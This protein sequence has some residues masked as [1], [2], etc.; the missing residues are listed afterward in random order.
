[1]AAVLVV[2]GCNVFA[3]QAGEAPTRTLTPAPV[4]SVTA[5]TPRESPGP[6]NCVAPP[7]A[8]PVERATP[9]PP[10]TAR[11]LPRTNTTGPVS[12][13]G[14][15]ALHDA[16]LRNYSYRLRAGEQLAVNATAGGRA[17]TFS[18]IVGG[19]YFTDAYAVGGTTHVHVRR[20]DGVK[21]LWE[22]P[23]RSDAR[24]QFLPSLTGREWLV[25]V[26]GQYNYTI[27]GTRPWN[28]STV[29]V[30]EARLDTPAEVGLKRVTELY[31]TVLVDRRGIV[32]AVDHY[33]RFSYVFESDGSV[34]VF[35]R[36]F[37]VTDVG[38][39]TIARPLAFCGIDRDDVRPGRPEGIGEAG[40]EASTPTDGAI[41]E[42]A[43][44]REATRT[45]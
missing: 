26:V 19:L 34:R 33:E 31:S 10:A 17:F 7:A 9:A 23:V 15:I 30:L 29:R 24:R 13:I 21:Y 28:G 43:T 44:T 27:T 14:L 37:R 3:G 20:P 6:T 39:A 11:P 35:D 16:V 41:N 12:G 4:P 25:D 40:D 8:T 36:A 2:S 1:M 18:G 45:E 42:S 5:E 22:R 38:T 32:R